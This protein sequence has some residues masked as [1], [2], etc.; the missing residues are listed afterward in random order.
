[1]QNARIAL[2][3][4][5]QLRVALTAVC[6]HRRRIAALPVLC[7]LIEK[8]GNTNKMT[9]ADWLFRVLMDWL[10]P[11]FQEVMLLD[12]LYGYL[13]GNAR[14]VLGTAGELVPLWAKLLGAL[15]LLAF[16]LKPLWRSLRA[17]FRPSAALPD[18]SGQALGASAGGCGCAADG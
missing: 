2:N 18:I 6:R 4:R 1:M 13:G 10:P 14:A 11:G 3:V 17:R 16:S 5:G 8:S 7:R 12:A 9:A 15:L